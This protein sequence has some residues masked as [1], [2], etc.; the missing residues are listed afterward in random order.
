VVR[1]AVGFQGYPPFPNAPMT[2]LVEQISPK[3]LI[4]AGKIY[5]NGKKANPIRLGDEKNAPP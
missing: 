1:S 5:L 2:W 4:F 3:T